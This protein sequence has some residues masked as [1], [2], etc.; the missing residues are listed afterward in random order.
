MPSSKGSST[1]RMLRASVVMCALFPAAAGASSAYGVSRLKPRCSARLCISQ[2]SQ[3]S[4]LK[5]K[6]SLTKQPPRMLRLGSGTSSVGW[7]SLST[8]RP[9]QVTQALLGSLNRGGDAS[10]VVPGEYLETVITK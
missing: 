9:P 1:R 4:G 3:V 6:A 10:L 2:P 7:T 5:R 8:P